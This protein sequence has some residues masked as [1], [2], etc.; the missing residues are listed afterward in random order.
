M[1]EQNF[2]PLNLFFFVSRNL[3]MIPPLVNALRLHGSLDTAGWL[4]AEYADMSKYHY[5]HLNPFIF[6]TRSQNW[7]LHFIINLK[8]EQRDQQE[9]E[10]RI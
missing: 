2:K 5:M 8:S 1:E 3:I 10:K 9:R 4:A 6:N 7:E